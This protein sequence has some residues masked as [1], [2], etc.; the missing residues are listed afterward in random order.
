[1][2]N[3]RNAKSDYANRRI[4]GAVFFDIDDISDQSS[5]LPHMLPTPSDFSK[6]VSNLGISSDN[7]LVIYAQHGAFSAARVWWTFKAFKHSKVSLLQGSIEGWQAAGGNLN[8]Q[9]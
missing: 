8:Y 9:C 4:K 2:N 7:H 5:S 3:S 1:M 6:S